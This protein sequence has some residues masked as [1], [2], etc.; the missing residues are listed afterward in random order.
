MLYIVTTF[1]S[2]L[3]IKRLILLKFIIDLFSIYK[4][5]KKQATF[6]TETVKL[7]VKEN[8]IRNCAET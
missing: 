5:H 8:F 2:L 4:L 3:K 6:D 7:Q 1:L